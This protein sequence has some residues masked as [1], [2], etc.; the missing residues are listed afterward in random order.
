[1]PGWWR[2][3]IR[4]RR[5]RRRCRTFEFFRIHQWFGIASG[6]HG[7]IQGVIT[8]STMALFFFAIVGLMSSDCID[9]IVLR[10]LSS[11]ICSSGALTGSMKSSCSDNIVSALPGT[12]LRCKIATAASFE[13][14][15]TATSRSNLGLSVLINLL[16]SDLLL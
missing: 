15:G 4:R 7:I 1:M 3:I 12:T 2:L 13:S 10:L 14:G 9:S 6:L 16:C 5:W 8:V 11:G